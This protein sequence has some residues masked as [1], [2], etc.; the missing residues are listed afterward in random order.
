MKKILLTLIALFLVLNAYAY[1]PFDFELGARSSGMGGA[2][3][4]MNDDIFAVNYNPGADVEPKQLAAD[5][6]FGKNYINNAGMFG[7]SGYW[8]EYQ[9]TGFAGYVK[10]DT[11]KEKYLNLSGAK[12]YESIFLPNITHVGV[13]LKYAGTDYSTKS[14]TD[15]AVDA[16]IGANYEL[17][18]DFNLG[19]S[20]LNVFGSKFYDFKTTRTFR[21]GGAYNYYYDEYNKF[22]FTADTVNNYSKWRFNLG[23]EYG[24]MN[25]YFLRAGYKSK[26]GDD[27]GLTFGLGWLT[28]LVSTGF[29]LDY[30]LSEYNNEDLHKFTA[31]INF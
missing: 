4:A 23:S 14:G 26:Y 18:Q 25:K 27:T 9:V 3:T 13:S 28:S 1:P 8:N 5:F 29:R 15:S 22:V 11:H 16:D 19:V 21:L 12:Y 6:S 30:S 7:Y 31:T 20:V 10:G 2:Y 17:M 24:Y